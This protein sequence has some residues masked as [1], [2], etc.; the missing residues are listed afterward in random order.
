MTHDFEKNSPNISKQ[1]L[2]KLM[3]SRQVQE[4]FAYL[5][6]DGGK[7]IRQASEAAAKGDYQKVKAL[8]SPKLQSEEAEHLLKQLGKPNG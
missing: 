5:Q 2:E 3:Q 4:L 1:E 8:L 6:R 7:A